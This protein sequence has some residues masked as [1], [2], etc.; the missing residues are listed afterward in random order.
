VAIS[1][2][3]LF[4]DKVWN[5]KNFNMGTE[6]D[7]AGEFIY[8][9]IHTF[10]Q[11]DSIDQDSMLFSFLYHVSVG[12]ERLQKII[13]VLSEKFTMDNHEEFEKSLITHSHAE[14]NRR[15][16]EST[17]LKLNSRENEFLQLL[18]TFYKSTRY[19]RFNFESQY[20]NEQRMFADFIVKYIPANKMQYHFI[21]N[22]ILITSDVKEL[23]GKVIGAISKKYYK[24][25]RD[26]CVRNNTYTYELRSGSKAERIFLSNH[27]NNSLQQQKIT[28]MIVFKELIVY[29]INTKNSN[30]FFRFIKEI[31]PLDL[32]IGLLN[33]YLSELSQGTISQSLI[34]EVEYLYDENSYSIER[35]EMVD[36]IGNTN[37][38]FEF[39][40]I[41]KCFDIIEG[42][43][44]GDYDYKEFAMQFPKQLELVEDEC[45]PEV[46]SEISELCSNYLSK[47]M[48]DAEFFQEVKNH[49]INFEECYNFESE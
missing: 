46:F 41:K 30:S 29:L 1:M 2:N 23:V 33:D 12:F 49:H 13:L 14:L 32:D 36:L 39:K 42:L 28:E 48:S 17:T 25:V 4:P 15:I 34:D 20:S 5:Y 35:M 45:P 11:L 27:R 38:M 7:I 31:Q 47:N 16:C 9:G 3:P 40:D 43:M 21:T 8:D 24:L 18:A 10:N 22:K 44:N 26:G 19:N 6:L 37:V